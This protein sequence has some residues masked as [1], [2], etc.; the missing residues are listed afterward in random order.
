M[1]VSLDKAV[2]ARLP[3][4]AHHFE[5]LVD[6]DAA[7]A[8][9]ERIRR[10]EP[11]TDD[12]VRKLCGVD[13]VFTHWSEGKRASHEELL[14]G[15]ETDEFVKV[16]R[17]ILTEGEIQLTADQRKKMAEQKHKRIVETILRNAWNPQTKTPHPKDRIERA[18]EEAKFHVD[19]LRRVEEQVEE[20]M[21]KLRPLIPIAFDEVQ[22]AVRI[23][24]EHAGHAYGSVRSLGTLKQE[25][26]QPDGSLVVVLQ[27]PAGMQTEVYDRLNAMTQGKV[28]VKLIGK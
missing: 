4:F 10:G 9:V 1:A 26:W 20:A 22:V 11:V 28:T 3:R 17:R 2:V 23:P 21:K 16:A 5:I 7:V 13:Y 27:M 12:D 18:L 14:K 24:K 15:F 6:P 8:A 25:E 19:P